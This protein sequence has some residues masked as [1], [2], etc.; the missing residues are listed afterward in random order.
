MRYLFSS[1]FLSYY[2]FGFCVAYLFCVCANPVFAQKE[3][4]K[5][6]SKESILAE[7]VALYDN[8]SLNKALEKFTEYLLQD[9]TNAMVYKKRGLCYYAEAKYRNALQDFNQSLKI[10]SNQADIYYNKALVYFYI[11]EI[12]KSEENAQKAISLQKNYAEAK[13][14]LGSIEI[15]SERYEVALMWFNGAIIDNKLSHYAYY[16]RGMTYF[17]LDNYKKA[18]EDWQK[19]IALNPQQIDAYLGRAE[20]YLSLCE[21]GGVEGKNLSK[22]EKEQEKNKNASFALENLETALKIN[23]NAFETHFVLGKYYKMK[24]DHKKACE[25]W[26]KSSALGSVEADNF[27]KKYCK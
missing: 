13:I 22:K 8:K 12:Q 6:P 2:H 4:P 20:L 5:P 3:T 23:P 9:T 14:L 10:L 19:A 11:G 25:C 7:A 15:Q 17:Y 1:L 24:K 27:L 21:N 18:L 26:K 16:N